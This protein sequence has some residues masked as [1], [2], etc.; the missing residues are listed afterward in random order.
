[1][2]RVKKAATGNPPPEVIKG[3]RPAGIF[4][5][6]ELFSQLSCRSFHSGTH[7]SERAQSMYVRELMEA[8]KAPV[9]FE[10]FLAY[11]EYQKITKWAHIDVDG[12]IASCDDTKDKLSQ[13]VSPS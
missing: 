13:K 7:C 12:I 6:P 3:E 4:A 5:D 1:M 9:A 10:Y 11:E 8:K 2:T